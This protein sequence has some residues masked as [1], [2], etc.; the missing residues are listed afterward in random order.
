MD[1]PNSQTSRTPARLAVDILFVEIKVLQSS[2]SDVKSSEELA[3]VLTERLTKRGFAEQSGLP[4]LKTDSPLMLKW[5][6]LQWEVGER[7]G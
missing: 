4:D 7:G 1:M 2:F 3:S 5:Q 6:Q